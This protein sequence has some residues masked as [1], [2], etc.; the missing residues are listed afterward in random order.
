MNALQLTRD[1]KYWQTVKLSWNFINTCLI[2]HQR[3]EWFTKLNR[4][5]I[6]FLVEPADDPSPY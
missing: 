1:E 3:G 5:G 2:D 4:L 6:P